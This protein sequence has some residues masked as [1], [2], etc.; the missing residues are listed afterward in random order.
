MSNLENVKDKPKGSD[1]P[2]PSNTN[3]LLMNK[4]A[5]ASVKEMTLPSKDSD[6]LLSVTFFEQGKQTP[7]DY[8]VQDLS[9]EIE[10][11]G[12]LNPESALSQLIREGMRHQLNYVGVGAAD[13][14]GNDVSKQLPDGMRLKIAQDDVLDARVEKLAKDKGIKTPDYVRKVELIGKDGA[15]L[16]QIGMVVTS[17]AQQLAAEL[18]KEK[19]LV[20]ISPQGMAVVE[21]MR[22]QFDYGGAKSVDKFVS[23]ISSKLPDGMKLKITDDDAFR[24][25]VVE[26]SK[27]DGDPIPDYIRVLELLDKNGKS[28]GKM[29]I[30]ISETKKEPEVRRNLT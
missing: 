12:R 1:V 18:G 6:R 4:S 14:L 22:N 9:K 25:K 20:D 30:S 13:S 8:I 17:S 5:N 11:A 16:G 23:N 2:S 10:K 24:K 29:G 19:K 26:G 15:S 21:E 28:L 3:D 27:K 7:R